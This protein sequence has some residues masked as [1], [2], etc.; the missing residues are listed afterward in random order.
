M[1]MRAHSS[2]HARAVTIIKRPLQNFP[3]GLARVN[4]NLGLW[5]RG[6]NF[7]GGVMLLAAVRY[8]VFVAS[9]RGR[10]AQSFPAMLNRAYAFLRSWA[11]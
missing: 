2:R 7:G 4:C 9:K 5:Q 8:A 3:L 11:R 1:R 6:G 10:G